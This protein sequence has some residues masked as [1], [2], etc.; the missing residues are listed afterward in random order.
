M[1]IVSWLKR[2]PALCLARA[3]SARSRREKIALRRANFTPDVES[4][5]VGVSLDGGDGTEPAVEQSLLSHANLTCLVYGLYRGEP[6]CRSTAQTDARDLPLPD[7]SFDHLERSGVIERKSS[8]Q[9]A[10]SGMSRRGQTP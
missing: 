4:L 1:P 5:P 3:V 2:G 9:N 8:R 7:D 10:I 6:R